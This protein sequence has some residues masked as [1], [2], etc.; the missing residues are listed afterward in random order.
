MRFFSPLLAA[1]SALLVSVAAAE[2]L[3]RSSA[4]LSCMEDSQFTASNFDVTLYRANGSANFE[5][6]AI[7]TLSGNFT[8][9]ILVAAY[10]I[11]IINRELSLC[12]ISNQLCPMSPGHFDIP[13]SAE[14][15]GDDVVNQIPGIAFKM[16]DLDAT[17]RVLVY[18][19]EGGPAVACV[20]A[21]LTNEKTV[22]TKYASWVIAAI[23]FAGLL[24][25][26][27][28]WLLGYVSTSAHIA[29]NIV[30]LFVYFQG[31]AIICMMGV[32]RV[33]PIAAAW[34]QNFMWTVGLIS[35]PF[36]QTIFNWYVQATG[37]TVTNIL[38]NK[39]IMSISVQKV[40]RGLEPLGQAVDFGGLVD[41]YLNPDNQDMGNSFFTPFQ[42]SRSSRYSRYAL[43][44]LAKRAAAA[45]NSTTDAAVT[46]NEHLDDYSSTTLVLRGI[47]RVAYL[48][49]IEITSLFLTAFVF[50]LILIVFTLIIFV[51]AKLML[52]LWAKLGTIQQT[53]F[54]NYRNSWKTIIKGILYR[55]AMLCFPQLTVMCLWELTKNDSPAVLVLAIMVYGVIAALLGFGAFKTISLARRSMMIHKNPAYILYSDPEALNRWGFLYVQFRATAYFFVIPVLGYIFVKCA[56]IAFGQNAGKVQGVLIFVVE[57]AF[58]IGISYYKPYMDKSTNGFNIGIAAINFINALFFM[59]FSSIFGLGPYVAGIMGVIFFILNAVFSL[60]LLIMILI[61]CTWAIFSSNPETRYKPMRDDRESFIP[62]SGAEKTA[63]TEL[64]ALGQSAQAGHDTYLSG[65]MDEESVYS[66][67][68]NGQ[69]PP[70]LSKK[71]SLNFPSAR[72]SRSAPRDLTGN[73]SYSDY[74]NRSQASLNDSSSSLGRTGSADPYNSTW[75]SKY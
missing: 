16:P 40:K 41:R 31:V 54:L 68:P 44:S 48:A 37:G 10:G 56:I 45:S 20:E 60:V 15:L 6:S 17:V 73:A 14:S 71:G 59:F 25:A 43:S 23:T 22:S 58:L 67:H 46:T 36:M 24:V 39:E 18:P 62:N 74:P 34:G 35:L 29:S 21:V 13:L 47:Q 50:F 3:I 30:S 42:E 4:L 26:A 9:N 70:Q 27:L 12:S 5:V 66:N 55:L 49:N 38:P 11:T 69:Q 57:L 61:S 28:I 7:S 33:P 63:V 72:L 19:K 8:A 52:E 64:D 32:D 75:Q 2:D 53:S 51:G 65:D 1:V